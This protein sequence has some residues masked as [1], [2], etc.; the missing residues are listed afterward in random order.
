LRATFDVRK[1]VAEGA[2]IKRALRLREMIRALRQ[3]KGGAVAIPEEGIVTALGRLA[4]RGVFAEPTTATAAAAL[5]RL[6]AS[7]AI[8][9]KEKTVAVLTGTGFLRPPLPW[10]NSRAARR[11]ACSRFT[12]VAFIRAL[13]EASVAIPMDG[14][15]RF[16]DNVFIERSRKHEDVSLKTLEK[17][18][19]K[20][21]CDRAKRPTPLFLLQTES[22]YSVESCLETAAAEVGLERTVRKRLRKRCGRREEGKRRPRPPRPTTLAKG[23]E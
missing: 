7:G 3:S 19:E 9:T 16:V 11:E 4:Q 18:Y 14:R 2:S 10:R 22:L 6:R 15:G 20:I 21:S 5:D 8:A 1:T 12:S 17:E 23:G 13:T